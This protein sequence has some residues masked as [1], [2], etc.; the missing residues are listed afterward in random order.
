MKDITVFLITC[1]NNPNYHYC[2]EALKKQTIEFKL[3]IIK[4]ISPMSKAFQEM[5][6]RCTTKYYIEVDEDM[7]LNSN[8]IEI[9][10]NA[11]IN[12]D[13]KRPMVCYQ[14]LDVHISFPI[15]GVKI[16]RYEDFK[17]YPYNLNHPSCEKDQLDRMTK[18]GYIF[19]ERDAKEGHGLV[20]IVV[21]KHSP[22]WTPELIFNRYYNL[23]QKYKI[24]G[25][26]WISR[27]P[28]KLL[29]IYLKD[30]NEINLYAFLGLIAGA[31]SKEDSETEKNYILKN[32]YFLKLKDI[33]K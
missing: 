1:G 22:Y 19:D 9:L 26:T 5:L 29:K 18:D 25:Y 23:W 30:P 3:D 12:I 17:K 27:L 21:G 8:A 31:L 4:D 13:E 15:Y 6:N 20:P 24:Y 16:Y 14:L 10:Y 28:N 33:F 32:D 7:I 11:I 2:L